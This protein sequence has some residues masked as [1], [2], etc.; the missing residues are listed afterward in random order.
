[1]IKRERSGRVDDEML[2]DSAREEGAVLV[3]PAVVV[4]GGA[5]APVAGD[6]D[7][8]LP[9]RGASVLLLLL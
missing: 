3:V 7:G 6:A 4:V 2:G 8:E 1:M 5:A 9:V